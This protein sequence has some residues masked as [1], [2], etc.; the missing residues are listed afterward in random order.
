VRRIWC[1]ALLLAACIPAVEDGVDVNGG[2]SAPPELGA[3]LGVRVAAD[4]VHFELHITNATTGAVGIEFPSAQ[5]YDFEILTPAGER[6]WQWSDGYMFA[7]AAGREELAAG[8]SRT[9]RE[10]WAQEGRTGDY[11]AVARLVSSNLPVE[12][13]TPVRLPGS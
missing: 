5:R 1:L 11:E 8:E 13:R 2:A 9:F 4:S 10:S 7:Q 6:V 12:L 3:T